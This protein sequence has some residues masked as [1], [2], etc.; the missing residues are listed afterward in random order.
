[1]Y[2][3]YI[4]VKF[5]NYIVT[6]RRISLTFRHHL[7]YFSHQCYRCE[8]LLVFTVSEAIYTN[9]LCLGLND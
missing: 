6:N 2:R 5:E 4:Q 3:V 9:N 8:Y 1:M 7:S